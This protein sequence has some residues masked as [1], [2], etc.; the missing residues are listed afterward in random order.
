MQ[1]GFSRIDVQNGALGVVV[2]MAKNTMQIYNAIDTKAS[3]DKR[4]IEYGLTF[5]DTIDFLHN[6]IINSFHA[7]FY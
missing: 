5:I 7:A 1:A 4:N 6:L 2:Q 3:N